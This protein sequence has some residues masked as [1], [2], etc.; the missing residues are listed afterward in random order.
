MLQLFNFVLS[1]HIQCGLAFLISF[2]CVTHFNWQIMLASM[3]M[4]VN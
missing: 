2:S 1:N 4:V 3:L